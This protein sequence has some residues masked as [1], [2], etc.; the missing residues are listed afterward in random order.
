MKKIN[1]TTAINILAVI[2]CII[3]FTPAPDLIKAIICLATAISY[4]F[5]ALKEG[6]TEKNIVPFKLFWWVISAVWFFNAITWG[7][8]IF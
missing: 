7:I 1:L 4:I 5:V 2:A 6:K 8:N 3:I